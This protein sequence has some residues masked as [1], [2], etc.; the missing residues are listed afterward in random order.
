MVTITYNGLQVASAT[1]LVTLTDVPNILKVTDTTGGTKASITMSFSGN[2]TTMV[3]QDGQFYITVYD[4]TIT[5]VMDYNNAVNKSF[6][7][8]TATTTTAAYVAKALRN[9]SNIAANFD[10]VNLGSSVLITAKDYKSYQGGLSC[11]TNIPDTYITIATSD[12]SSN[13]PLQGALIDV[14]VFAD[15]E[16]VTTLEKSFYD[17]ECAFNVSPVLSTISKHGETV[18]YTFMI[19]SI[20][21]GEYNELE[22]TSENHSTV[23]Y[24]VNMGEKYLDAEYVV[25]AQNVLRGE[26]KGTYN[27]TILYLYENTI[28]FSFYA[29]MGGLYFTVKTLD[30]S[31]NVITSYTQSWMYPFIPQNNSKLFEI[32]FNIG[33][34]DGVYYVDLTFGDKTLRYTVIK[35]FKMG[36]QCTR[37]YWRNSYGGK[38]FFDWTGS[39]T[40]NHTSDV[41]TFQ[42]NIFNYYED[43]TDE[44]NKVY[45]TKVEYEVTLKSHLMEKDGIWIFNDLLQSKDVWVVINGK[46]YKIIVDSIAVE[47]QSQN[48]IYEATIKYKYSMPTSF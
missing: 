28:P 8:S 2:L 42:K 46:E 3:S 1:N 41:T 17:G 15:G 4:E 37:I 32:D 27:K 36:E 39:R 33:N 26:N 25:Y 18:P 29:I 47:E 38:S 5:N 21:N 9:C 7:I 35:P 14:D 13:S 30:S 22:T 40:E 24:M 19:S 11:V 45:D 48:N 12:G 43:T 6:Y 44:L 10:V 31:F 34:L 16:Y 20:N 23:G